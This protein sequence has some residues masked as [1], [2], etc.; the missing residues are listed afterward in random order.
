MNLKPITGSP[1]RQSMIEQMELRRLATKLKTLP[2]GL[3]R[4]N[5][6]T[7]ERRENGNWEHR[8][9]RSSTNDSSI[10]LFRVFREF[11]SFKILKANSERLSLRRSAH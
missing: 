3:K 4:R 6:E 1:L 7:R 8:V 10:N 9:Q 5:Y 2:V 11:R